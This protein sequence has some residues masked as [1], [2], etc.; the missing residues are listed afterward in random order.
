MTTRPEARPR[1]PHFSSGPCAKRPGWTPAAL[2]DA[3]LGRSHRA[4]LGK[5]K[6]K[7]AIDLTRAVLEV[8]DDYRIGIVPASDTGA[9]EMAMWSLLGPRP[10]EMLAW[11]SFGETW[12]TDAVKQLRLDARVTTAPYGRLPDL[13][14]VDTKTR[15][16]VFTW[17]GTTSGVRVPDAGWIAADREGLTL[18]DATS[19]AFAQQ[20]DWPKL[21]V[22]TFSWQKA[23]GGEAAHGM[24]VLSPRAVARLESYSPPWPMPKLFRLTKGGKLIEG[25]FEG[26]TIN[27][28]SMLAVEDYLDAL[29]WGQAAGGLAGLCARADANARVIGDWVARTPWIGNL[30]QDP[31]TASNT[32]V[33]LVVT[34]PDVT[35][36]GPEA[37]AAVAKGI[38][39]TL[40]REGV[41]H[42][43]GSYRDAPPGLRIWCGATVETADLEALTPWLDW[44][45]AQE[46]A[47]LAARAA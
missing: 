9:V 33:C 22:V 36:K 19:A 30:A 14:A 16:L 28:P 3:A 44:A 4:R 5:G 23:L 25:I 27:T 47:R 43:I 46:K 38:A 24:L 18:C 7:E 37:G 40:E 32:S 42:D 45:F 34:D 39:I 6:L 1:V 17:N 20:L 21:D 41:A 8:P 15:D 12:V 31:A 11:E 13:S 35:A 29:R 2:G 26:E 10:V